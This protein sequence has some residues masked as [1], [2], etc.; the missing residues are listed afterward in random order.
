VLSNNLSDANGLVE[1]RAACGAAG[2][3]LE[4]LGAASGRVSERPEEAIRRADLVF[5]KARAALEAVATGCAVVLCD[6]QGIGPLVT[7]EAF[8]ELR[9]LNF[10]YRTLLGPITREVVATRIG[11]YDAAGAAR[12]SKRARAEAGLDAAF[13][14]IA[15]VWYEVLANEAPCDEDA[16]RRAA[17]RYVRWVSRR[18][19]DHEAVRAECGRLGEELRKAHATLPKW[20]RRS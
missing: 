18:V 10:G 16:E 3:D 9:A 7:E 17:A 19:K 15:A 14:A 8:A 5:A 4:T 13:D 1:L 12:A 2:I 20:W 6:A 11:A